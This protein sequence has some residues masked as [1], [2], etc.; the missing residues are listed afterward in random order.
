MG[1]GHLLKS[2]ELG[3]QESY[4]TD[5]CN[6]IFEKGMFKNNKPADSVPSVFGLRVCMSQLMLLS[7]SMSQALAET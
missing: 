7:V 4:V 6:M 1:E 2:L 5:T 3:M